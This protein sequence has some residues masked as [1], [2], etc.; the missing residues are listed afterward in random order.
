MIYGGA[1]L[2][3]NDVRFFKRSEEGVCICSVCSVNELKLIFDGRLHTVYDT[4]IPLFV[5]IYLPSRFQ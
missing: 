4:R 3:E 5:R 1:K 2:K